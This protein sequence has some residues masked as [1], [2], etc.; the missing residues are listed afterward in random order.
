V[1]LSPADALRRAAAALPGDGPT[2]PASPAGASTNGA[3]VALGDGATA[4]PGGDGVSQSA[5]AETDRTGGGAGNDPAEGDAETDPAEPDLGNDPAGEDARA[6]TAEGGTTEATGGAG[7]GAGGGGREGPLLLPSPVT[8]DPLSAAREDASAPADDEL[9]VST[10]GH[11]YLEGGSSG[12]PGDDARGARDDAEAGPRRFAALLASLESA[13]VVHEDAERTTIRAVRPVPAELTA[14]ADRPL[15]DGDVEVHLDAAG[16][17]VEIRVTVEGA[18]ARHRGVVRFADWDTTVT[19]AA[20]VAELDATPWLDEQAAA[21][22]REGVTALAPTDVP[23]GL[24]LQDIRPIPAAEAAEWGQPCGQFELLYGP[25]HDAA[26]RPGTPGMSEAAGSPEAAGTAATGGA[27]G[28]RLAVVLIPAGC[29]VRADPAPFATGVHGDRPS[30][31]LDGVTQVRFDQTVVQ[32]DGDL[33]DEALT[34]L[35]ASVVPFDLDAELARVS[36][37][38]ERAWR[39]PVGG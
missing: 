11:L 24:S 23:D 12:A 6:G 21:E 1:R 37:L 13:R 28:Q 17:P 14:A 33:T 29:A 4:A 26:G 30:R 35:V 31:E 19:V 25:G 7:G 18:T 10:L 3:I 16:R 15:P 34:A 5:D 39:G 32:I 20:P 9:V 22:A 27:T 38:A 8:G 36:L 2:A